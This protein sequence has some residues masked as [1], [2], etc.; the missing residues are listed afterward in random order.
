MQH[1]SATISK[2]KHLVENIKACIV[3]DESK[4]NCTTIDEEMW[5]KYQFGNRQNP[6]QAIL[7]LWAVD[8]SLTIYSCS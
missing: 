8:A 5:R 2:S 7:P 6:K 4:S 1:T 3:K